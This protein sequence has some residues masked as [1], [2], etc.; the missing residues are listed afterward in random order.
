MNG[1]FHNQLVVSYCD[2]VDGLLIGPY[3]AWPRQRLILHLCDNSRILFD[4]RHAL[5]LL[6]MW[7]CFGMMPAAA[8]E[9]KERMVIGTNV[10]CRAEPSSSARA[11]LPLQLGDL[12]GA[13]RETRVDGATWYFDQ[14]HIRGLNP[15]CWV[16]GPIT[17]EFTRSNPEPA[18]IALIDHM[19]QRRDKVP[20]AE[21]VVAENLLSGDLYRDV[22]RSS[23]LLQ[24]RKL[25]LV[26]RAVRSADAPIG[27]NEPKDALK[28][29]W[30]LAHEAQGLLHVDPFG[31]GWYVPSEPLWKLYEMYKDMP[32]GDD[33]AW[34]AAQHTSPTDECYSNC[35]LKLKIIDGPMQYWTRL[36]TGKAIREALQKAI[37]D[38]KYVAELAC[39][40]KNPTQASLAVSAPLLNQIRN[41][42]SS[43]TAA[44]KPQLLD[45]LAQA[46][47]CSRQR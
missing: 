10:V 39:D 38:A 35:V 16:F 11:E 17:T 13:S 36:P 4:M 41:S 43:V 25:L 47:A 22:V 18:L 6:A 9:L 23:G 34:T 3:K 15:T 2:F 46:E 27:G 5:Y 19:L 1:S 44:D 42:L 40:D 32:W 37:A 28:K 30:A 45:Y 24:F 8:Q 21:F 33:L 26:D 12:I 7:I 29:A 14:Y 20:F 31:G